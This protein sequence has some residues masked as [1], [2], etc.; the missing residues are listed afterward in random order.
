MPDND[1]VKRALA[2]AKNTLADANR[3]QA[4]VRGPE[5]PSP[6]PAAPASPAPSNGIGKEA[7][8]AAAGIK[9]R[10]EQAKALG[11]FKKGGTVP[12]TGLYEL[13]KDEK[14]IPAKDN[15]E[16]KPA[17][18]SEAKP[19]MKKAVMDKAT[20]GLGGSKKPKHGIKHTHIEHHSDGSH[21]VKHQMHT[22]PDK[23][24]MDDN[25]NSY[26]V[27]DGGDLVEK[28]KQ[29]LGAGEAAPA[30]PAP[31]SAAPAPAA[32]APSMP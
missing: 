2:S 23:V 28:L 31:S 25:E 18:K 4:S 15:K 21:T 20:S 30:A 32:A 22:R 9:Y 29:M 26:A 19:E 7:S 6:K 27:K 14:V 16:A 13:H 8:D 1:F 24:G 11:S 3:F 5:R 17:M 10:G 12:K